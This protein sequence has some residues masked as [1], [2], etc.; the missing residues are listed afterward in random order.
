MHSPWAA[1]VCQRCGSRAEPQWAS[2][3]TGPSGKPFRR[4][5]PARRSRTRIG[6]TFD[7]SPPNTLLKNC[8]TG[9]SVARDVPDVHS[10]PKRTPEADVMVRACPS[11]LKPRSCSTSRPKLRS[12]S[13]LITRLG[14]R[15][16]LGRSAQWGRPVARSKSGTSCQCRSR[17]F[18]SACPSGAGGRP[19][20]GDYLDRR[21]PAAAGSTSLLVRGRSQRD[22]RSLGGDLEGSQSL[23][24]EHAA[25][26]IRERERPDGPLCRRAGASGAQ[27]YARRWTP[28]LDGRGDDGAARR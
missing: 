9:P 4:F 2:T 23:T 18:L 26:V 12:T 22:T 11:S 19:S 6:G 28:R 10:A 17:E 25:R 3:I 8:T 7:A 1:W 13:S 24:I 16:C 14:R 21:Q 27:R 15:G 20:E 5:G